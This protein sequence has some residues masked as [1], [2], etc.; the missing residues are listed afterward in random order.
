MDPNYQV[1]ES[2]TVKTN[3]YGTVSGDFTIPTA[4]LRPEAAAPV[5]ARDGTAARVTIDSERLPSRAENVIATRGRADRRI[6]VIAHIDSKPGTPGAVDNAAGVVALL[7][8]AARLSPRRQRDLPVGVELLAV[9]GE[10]HF[11]APG[12]LD[13]LA[14]NEDHLADISLVVNIDG[15][16]YR[17]ARSAYSTYNL[18]GGTQAHIDRSFSQQRSI[19]TGP[20][21]YQSDHAI[22]AMRGRPVVAITTELVDEMLET[23]FHA[24]TDTPDKVDTDLVADLAEGLSRLVLTWP[25]AYG[26]A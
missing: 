7:D 21:W 5:L 10:D 13:W 9:N 23:L 11:A 24:P 25:G 20:E 19:T 22:F 18:A 14:A 15:A 6:T 3:A 4:N 1:V 12:E 8:L 16:G 2:K 17:G 26:A